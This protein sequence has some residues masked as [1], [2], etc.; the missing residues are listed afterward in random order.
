LSS[1]NLDKE[2]EKLLDTISSNVAKI[3]KEKDISQLD[4]ALE[5]GYKSAA[6]IG[7]IELRKNNHHFNIKQLYKISKILEVE[8]YKFLQEPK[9]DEKVK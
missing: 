5:M 4:L 1:S 8:I 7:K 6:Y 9:N 3:R 2:A